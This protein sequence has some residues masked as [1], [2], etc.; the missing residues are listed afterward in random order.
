MLTGKDTVGESCPPTS[1]VLRRG[2]R[3]RSRRAMHF[4]PDEAADR[5]TSRTSFASTMSINSVGL[6]SPGKNSIVLPQSP[7]ETASLSCQSLVRRPA[8][9]ISPHQFELPISP[10]EIA[11]HHR[12]WGS[13]SLLC[14]TFDD[15]DQGA[16]SRQVPQ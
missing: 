7:T 4:L 16:V 6:A 13:L 3:S 8:I 1:D 15:G 5:L 11:G 14:C 10:M 9:F 12:D 2:G